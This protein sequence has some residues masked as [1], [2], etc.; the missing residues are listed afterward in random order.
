MT[1]GTAGLPE[2]LAGMPATVAQLLSARTSGHDDRFVITSDERL[3]F[4]EVDRRSALLA[5]VLLRQG[6]A[7]GSR[8]GIL[9]PNGVDWVVTWLAAARIGALTVPL[10]TFAPPRTRSHDPTYRCAVPGDGAGI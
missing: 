10:S 9:Y 2:E 8:V 5:G 4:G 1:S 6:V 7:K 3:T